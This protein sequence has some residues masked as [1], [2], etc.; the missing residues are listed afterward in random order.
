MPTYPQ[1]AT[2]RDDKGQVATVRFYVLAAD[3]GD[4]LTAAQA[5]V[6]AISAMTNAAFDGARGAYTT[7][8]AAHAYGANATFESVEDKAQVTFQTEVGSM[9]R[10]KIPAPKEAIMLADGET[11]NPANGLVATFAAAMAAGAASRDGVAI[12]DL[13]GGVRTRSRFQRRFNIFTLNPA[14]TGPGE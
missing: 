14:L 3:E 1:S 9:H 13:I 10:Y 4:A 12:T 8:P 2:Y 6:A 7:V 11:L 5:I